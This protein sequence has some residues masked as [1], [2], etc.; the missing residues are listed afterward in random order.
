VEQVSLDEL[1]RNIGI[2]HVV[3]AQSNK[4]TCVL[5]GNGD[6]GLKGGLL[7]LRALDSIRTASFENI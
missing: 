6:Y 1:H 4:A 5:V 2:L 7:G 3:P